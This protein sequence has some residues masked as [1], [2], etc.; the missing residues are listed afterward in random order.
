M[1]A[2]AEPCYKVRVVSFQEAANNRWEEYQEIINCEDIMLKEWGDEVCKA[3]S[4]VLLELN[5]YNGSGRYSSRA[6]ELQSGNKSQ[7]ERCS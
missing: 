4:N 5:E 1:L 6:L 7:P 3:V 2:M